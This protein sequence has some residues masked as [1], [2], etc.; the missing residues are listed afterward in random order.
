[1]ISFDGHISNAGR[2]RRFGR[3]FF[4]ICPHTHGCGFRRVG[5]T[6]VFADDE[7]PRKAV[8][9]AREVADVLGVEH[10]VKD[11]TKRFSCNVVDPFVQAYAAAKRRARAWSATDVRIPLFGGG[12]YGGLHFVARAL[13]E[14]GPSQRTARRRAPRFL[15]RTNPICCQRCK[16]SS[17]D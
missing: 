12:R 1:M 16:T 7:A 10:I 2:R 5:V 14:R 13:C 6:C 9:D 4:R 15:R 11:C 3:R 8:S 17:P